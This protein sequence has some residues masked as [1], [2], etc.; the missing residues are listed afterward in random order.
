MDKKTYKKNMMRLFLAKKVIF[1]GFIVIMAFIGIIWFA[2]P[3]TSEVEKRELTKFPKLTISGIWNGSFFTDVDTWYADTYPLREKLIADYQAFQSRFGIRTEQLIEASPEPAEVEETKP[4]DPDENLV[5]GLGDVNVSA[6]NVGSIYIAGNSGYGVYA[7]SESGSRKYAE[8]VSR[9]ADNLKGKA[10]VYCLIGPIS[11]GV[12]LSDDVRKSIHCDDEDVATEKM[13][14]MMSENVKTVSTHH[15]LKKHNSEYI[16]FRTDHHWTARGAYY[17]YK[18]FC[19]VKGIEPERLEDFKTMKFEGFLGSFY[20]QSNRSRQLGDNPDT[21]EAFIP[22]DTNKMTTYFKKGSTFTEN[23]W[24]IVNDVSHYA[25]TELYSCFAGADQAFSFIH[26][27]K[28]TDGSSILVIKDSFGN[29]FIPF[30]TDHYEYVYWIDYRYYK[31]FISWQGKSDPS[32]SS[33]VAEKNIKDV[34]L[35]NNINFTGNIKAL[36]TLDTMYR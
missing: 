24:K 32:I 10:D 4:V 18:E 13:Y 12:M 21:V 30:L 6:E 35:L 22:N 26:N 19:K 5:E 28:K 15:A 3:K 23:E 17:A 14:D 2:R 20:T 9:V 11:A 16:F 1:F 33:L 8:I 36:A 31:A 34:L 29:A 27:E 25:K 7:Y